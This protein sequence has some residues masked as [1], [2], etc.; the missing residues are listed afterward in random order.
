MQS[1]VV[2]PTVHL[3]I[4]NSAVSDKNSWN[5]VYCSVSDGVKPAFTGGKNFTLK[6]IYC[7]DFALCKKQHQG[8]VAEDTQNK[9]NSHQTNQF[10][11]AWFSSKHIY[12]SYSI[13]H[14]NLCFYGTWSF[15]TV[16]SKLHHWTVSWTSWI[17]SMP[18]YPIP[19]DQFEY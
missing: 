6:I 11:S 18:T 1:L 13:G 17:Q 14:K 5:R 3:K 4:F 16:L 8:N 10:Q 2:W 9:I 12:C 15:I 19:Q 7:W